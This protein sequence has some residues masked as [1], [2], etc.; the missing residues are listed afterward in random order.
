MVQLHVK[1]RLPRM[2]TLLVEIQNLSLFVVNSSVLPSRD[3]ILDII[4]VVQDLSNLAVMEIQPRRFVRLELL[5]IKMVPYRRISKEEIIR[6][7]K[8]LL[9]NSSPLTIRVDVINW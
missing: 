9:H 2:E 5:K 1:M 4:T 8:Y 7:L 3:S 6:T